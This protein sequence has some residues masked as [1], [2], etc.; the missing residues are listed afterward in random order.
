MTDSILDLTKKALG[1]DAEYDVFDTDIIMHINS[2]FF[3]LNQL[4][5]GPDETF[6]IQNK[7]QKWSE[8]LGERKNFN[9]VKTYMYLRVRLLFDPP[10][11]SFAITAMEKQA[12]Q[13][14]WRL[15]VQVEG[16]KQNALLL[17]PGI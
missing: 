14:E 12:E 4:G 9:A 3:T 8:F 5:I 1:L 6:A 16:D 17:E 13:L 7:D 2:T 11:T 15:N 10:S